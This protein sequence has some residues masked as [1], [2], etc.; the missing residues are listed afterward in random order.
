[1]K[2]FSPRSLSHHRLLLLISFVT[3]VFFAIQLWTFAI[4]SS[5]ANHNLRLSPDNHH[6]KKRRTPAALEF[7]PAC[8]PH[9][10][11]AITRDN[12]TGSTTWSASSPITRIYFYHVRKA[13]GTML[14][15]FLKGVART[16][17]IN[18]EIQENKYAREEIGSHPGTMYVSNLRDPVERSISHFKYEGRWDCRQMIKNATQYIPTLQ[19]A[20]KFEDWDQTGG[21]VPSPCDQPCSFDQC[22]VNCYIQSF[23]GHG[24]SLDDWKTEFTLAQE[25]LFQY[26]LIFVYDRFKDPNYVKAIEQFF[27]VDKVFNLESNYWCGPEAKQ[28]NKLYPLKTK[29]EAILKLEHLNAMDTRFYK[30]AVSCWDDDVAEYSFPKASAGTF[31][32]QNNI[33]ITGDAY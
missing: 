4:V 21:F 24:C 12:T 25:R 28:A 26:N 3:V 17:K 14:R 29:F 10:K 6:T 30:E 19:N 7:S 5:N 22:A 31:A 15:K 32:P 2:A 27:G 11:V 20:N 8:H 1:M 33:K 23:S 9:H 16:H 18:L 13:G